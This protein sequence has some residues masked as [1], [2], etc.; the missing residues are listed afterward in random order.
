MMK[1]DLCNEKES[2]YKYELDDKSTIDICEDCGS[3]VYGKNIHSVQ[4]SR[5]FHIIALLEY[6]EAYKNANKSKTLVM[7]TK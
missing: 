5:L 3:I 2:K 4:P 1:C 6:V 7:H